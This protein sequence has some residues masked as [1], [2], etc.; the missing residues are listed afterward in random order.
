MPDYTG[1]PKLDSWLRYSSLEHRYKSSQMAGPFHSKLAAGNKRP[2]GPKQ[3]DWLL[4]RVW[5]A[6]PSIQKVAPSLSQSNL[7]TACDSRNHRTLPKRGSAKAQNSTCH[8][9]GQF[10]L[11]PVFTTKK[12][13]GQKSVLEMSYRYLFVL[14]GC[15]LWVTCPNI[16]GKKE[17]G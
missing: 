12:D 4:N 11:H 16:C 7:A 1:H 2:V 5:F 10:F 17:Y 13:G 3:C 15:N 8:M 14:C 9:C 6:T